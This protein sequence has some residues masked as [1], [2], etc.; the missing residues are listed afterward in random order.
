MTGKTLPRLNDVRS[1]SKLLHR[2]ARDYQIRRKILSCPND[3]VDHKLRI[4]EQEHPALTHNN[5]GKL[6]GRAVGIPIDP[7]MRKDSPMTSMVV[8]VHRC[9]MMRAH[10]ITGEGRVNP[11]P[12][13]DGVCPETDLGEHSKNNSPSNMI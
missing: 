12:P 7:S 6:M 5:K 11:D 9:P 13:P 1:F 4:Q 3:P 8:V 2:A 10:R